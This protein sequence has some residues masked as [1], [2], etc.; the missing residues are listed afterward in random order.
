MA[1]GGRTVAVAIPVAI[2]DGEVTTI[3]AA[4][5][6]RTDREERDDEAAGNDQ[7]GERGIQY[8]TP[9]TK[10]SDASPDL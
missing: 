6:S 2:A 10:P 8:A 4:P 7:R 5:Q 1:V 3:V 9:V